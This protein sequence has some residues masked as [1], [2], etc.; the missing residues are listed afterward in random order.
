MRLTT[1][2]AHGAGMLSG[3]ASSVGIE[4]LF[5]SVTVRDHSA[6]LSG[7]SWVA[8]ETVKT[9]ARPT[10]ISYSFPTKV[11]SQTEDLYP[12]ATSTWAA[13]N[14]AERGL[15]RAAL[16]AWGDACGVTF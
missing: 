7:F 9:Y 13:F 5:G 16:K 14:A 6:L 15:A 11:P 3:E 2:S 10:F 12:F 1:G 4:A 8:P